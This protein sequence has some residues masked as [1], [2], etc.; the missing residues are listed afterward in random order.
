MKVLFN[1]FA[2]NV[3]S[4][5]FKA[6]G[7]SNQQKVDMSAPQDT[8]V[9]S[10]NTQDVYAQKLNA[11]FPNGSLNKIYAQMGKELG[12]DN[13]PTLKFYG[14]SDGVMAGGFTFG[15]NEISFS[16]SEIFDNNHKVVMVKN[17]MYK[18]L[19]SPNDNMPLFIDKTNGE[20]FVNAQRPQFQKI[21][22][23]LKLVSMTDDDFR[24]F[25]IHKMYHELIHAQQHMIMRSTEGI[26]EKEI[27]KQMRD[28]ALSVTTTKSHESLY[29]QY[30]CN[31]HE[32][33]R[34]SLHHEFK[35]DVAKISFKCNTSDYNTM[36]S[37][38]YAIL[39]AM[40]KDLNIERRDIKACLSAKLVSGILDLS[41]VIYDSV[42]GGAGHSRRLV[43]KDGKMLHS[44]FMSALRS[45]SECNCEPSCYNCLRSYENQKIH[46]LLDRKLA[47]EFLQQ[48]VGTVETVEEDEDIP[49]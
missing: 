48:F 6:D 7:V 40:A 26:G 23:D 28:G 29:G 9:R 34:R 8:F 42:P 11:L 5:S 30:N 44:I 35:T 16:L 25:V 43:T 17:G 49:F 19:T 41:I 12:I 37:V 32:L 22:D 1:S 10:T 31:C 21:V 24:K 3:R 15:K 20:Q 46:D 36:V 47:I 39:N 38:M 45:M 13:M 14:P 27:E 4:I 18:L 33:V 2:N